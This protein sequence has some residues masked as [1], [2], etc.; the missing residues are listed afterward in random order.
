MAGIAEEPD[1]ERA[2][3]I[4]HVRVVDDFAS[5]VDRAIRKTGAGLI[6]IVHRAVYAI[7]EAEFAR[8]MQGQPAGFV[9]VAGG[10]DAIDELAVIT[11]R[12]LTGNGLLE[13]ESFSEN[14]W[15]HEAQQTEAC[16]LSSPTGRNV[17]FALK[18]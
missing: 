2:Q 7:A 15:R 6:G 8:E 10:F 12:Q 18:V 4:V 13:I 9:A 11:R 17:A 1:A 14:E 16:G 3:L 5:Q